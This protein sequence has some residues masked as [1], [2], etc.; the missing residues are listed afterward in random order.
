MEKLV[1]G[2]IMV[3]GIVRG[4]K[5]L[6]EDLWYRELIEKGYIPDEEGYY[7]YNFCNEFRNFLNFQKN[8]V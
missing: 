3:I 8:N 6:N 7:H 5:P 1:C 2:T 4:S